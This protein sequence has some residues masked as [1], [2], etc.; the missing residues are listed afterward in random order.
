M[1]KLRILVVAAGILAA[2]NPIAVSAQNGAA[3]SSR[4]IPQGG[5]PRIIWFFDGR[6]DARDFPTNGFFPGDFAANP[7]AAA[8][9][10]AGI[11]GSN[12]DHAYPSRIVVG[13]SP[14]QMSCVHRHSGGYQAFGGNGARRRC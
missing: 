7:A 2:S 1:S 13:S 3:A 5:F 9:G 14:D 6:D 12:P 8:I 11:F 10:A 4:P